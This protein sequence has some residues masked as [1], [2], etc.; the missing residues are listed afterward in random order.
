MKNLHGA[1][2]VSLLLL[3]QLHW[4]A[5]QSL[6]V[7]PRNRRT[8][9]CEE[10]LKKVLSHPTQS[11]NLALVRMLLPFKPQRFEMVMTTSSTVPR[12]GSLVQDMLI[13]FSSWP[14]QILMP[15]IEVCLDLL[16]KQMQR[17]SLLA[18]RRPTWVNAAAIRAV[19]HSTMSA[20]LLTN[21]SVK[22]NQV[23]G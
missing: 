9:G 20:Y 4:H 19:S 5:L 16:L 1:T 17:A 23:V 2:L 15:A 7:Q 18:K 14:K 6:Q 22:V 3:T 21:W 12:C 11:L 13:S 10:S 8:S